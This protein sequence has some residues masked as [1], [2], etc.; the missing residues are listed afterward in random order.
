MRQVTISK[1]KSSF[2]FRCLSGTEFGDLITC[3]DLLKRLYIADIKLTQHSNN[4]TSTGIGTRTWLFDKPF[5]QKLLHYLGNEFVNF[6][7]I[8][9]NVVHICPVKIQSCYDLVTIGLPYTRINLFIFRL[10]CPY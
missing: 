8:L 6:I 9:L 2:I 4:G 10:C 7:Y 1:L 5:V 3:I